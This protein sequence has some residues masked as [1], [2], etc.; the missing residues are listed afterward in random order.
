MAN[1]FKAMK[2]KALTKFELTRGKVNKNLPEILIAGGVLLTVTGAVIACIKT[3]KELEVIDDHK[4]DMAEINEHVE[5][6]DMTKEEAK[7]AKFET[8]K[9]TVY[10]TVVNYLAAFLFYAAGTT[11][12]ITGAVKGKNMRNDLAADLSAT[13]GAFALYRERI[14][15]RLGEEA[16]SDIYYGRSTVDV[17]IM[18]PDG[19]TE[20]KH[21]KT[22]P[23]KT[24]H[25]LEFVFN[26][27][28]S[29]KFEHGDLGTKYNFTLIKSVISSYSD[30]LNA[31]WG[32]R[33]IRLNAILNAIGLKEE[34][35]YDNYGWLP[36]DLGGVVD[37]ISAGLEKYADGINGID[38]PEDGELILEFNA[39]FIS[40]KY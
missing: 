19:T 6:G 10:K 15:D 28:T 38:I 9:G 14:R 33:P 35:R 1:F 3:K 26:D 8:T 39:E 22:D 18:N 24:G 31:P 4:L 12:I 29:S 13:M 11:C 34:G 27:Q 32:G 40:D 25:P 30:E 37:K 23:V 16:E 2:A 17:G 36:K 7:K 21:Y 20:Q 5:N